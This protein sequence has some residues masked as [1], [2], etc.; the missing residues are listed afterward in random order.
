M[1]DLRVVEQLARALEAGVELLLAPVAVAFEDVAATL[2]EHDQRA[3]V[4]D[5]DGSTSSWSAGAGD[6]RGAGRA[7]G[8]GRRGDR[9]RARR[10]RRRRSRACA[11][12]EP[13]KQNVAARAPDTLAFRAAR[14]IE[15]A[16]EHVARITRV[17]LARIGRPAATALVQ[18][19]TGFPTRS[20]RSSVQ[21]GSKS[22]TLP[23]LMREL[24]GGA[25]RGRPA[26][27]A[28]RVG[29]ERTWARRVGLSGD[30]TRDRACRASLSPSA[31]ARKPCE[32]VSDGASPASAFVASLRCC[33]G[34]TKFVTTRRRKRACEGDSWRTSWTRLAPRSRCEL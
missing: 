5:G 33:L 14:Q 1:V 4:A 19:A 3:V 7:D 13:R 30:R 22:M 18:L 27:R 6:R 2:G 15:V 12:S 16:R 8:P 20:S 24:A 32:A 23:L 10:G 28:A 9:R 17:A 34:V 21:R 25:G 11:T 31:A 29:D 26:R